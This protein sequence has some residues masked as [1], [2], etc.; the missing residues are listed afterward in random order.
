MNTDRDLKI[1]I[2]DIARDLGVP[3]DFETLRAEEEA[4]DRARLAEMQRFV[5]G[6]RSRD[7]GG[8]FLVYVDTHLMGYLPHDREPTLA[9]LFEAYHKREDER[10]RI[11]EAFANDVA[12]P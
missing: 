4:A 11:A 6:P 7:G 10:G 12:R 9:E 5:Y 8:G 3:L 2:R 1:R